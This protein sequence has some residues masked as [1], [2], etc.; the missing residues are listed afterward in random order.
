[1]AV[2]R[3]QLRAER[4]RAIEVGLA[5]TTA[6]RDTEGTADLRQACVD[7]LVFVLTRFDERDQRLA[8][9]YRN[10]REPAARQLEEALARTGTSRDALAKLESALGAASAGSA[11]DADR[12]WTELAQ[13][14]EGP[15]R[16]RRTALEA[17]L[18]QNTRIED[19]REA[20]FVDADSILDERARYARVAAR[21]LPNLR[22][23]P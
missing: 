3:N 19:W 15:W 22:P 23:D 18:E 7:Y 11:E 21:A 10:R 6:A 16:T 17:L 14:F 13:F 2:I 9:L 1:M 12:R 4:D 20:S 5:C 8:E